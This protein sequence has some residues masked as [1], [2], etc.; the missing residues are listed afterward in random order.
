M[1]DEFFRQGDVERERGMNVSPLMDRNVVDFPRS[2]TQFLKFVVVPLFEAFGQV[3]Q[4]GKECVKQIEFNSAKWSEMVDEK[5]N[6]PEEPEKKLV[7]KKREYLLNTAL[8]CANNRFSSSA[9]VFAE[10]EE[11]SP[12]FQHETSRIEQYIPQPR[13]SR[14][15]DVLRGRQQVS[16]STPVSAPSVQAIY[17]LAIGKWH[18]VYRE[19]S[20]FFFSLFLIGK[21]M[22]RSRKDA[23]RLYRAVVL[24]GPRMPRL[25]RRHPL[26]YFQKLLQES[27]L[28]M[29][30]TKAETEWC[31]PGNTD[32]LSALYLNEASALVLFCFWRTI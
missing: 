22:Y 24:S 17:Q 25:P 2:Q 4:V 12:N 5:P 15:S 27:P 29:S 11:G 18:A 23:V 1:R 8:F 30:N 13:R 20:D 6:K 19:R 21:W 31:L 28:I 16:C 3:M 32:I 9:H 10:N 26:R 7:E 14:S